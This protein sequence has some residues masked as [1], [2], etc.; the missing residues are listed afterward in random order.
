MH[1]P[2]FWSL[3]LILAVVILLFGGKKLPELG[4]SIGEAIKNFKKSIKDNEREANKTATEV[5]AVVERPKELTHPPTEP[6][7]HTQPEPGDKSSTT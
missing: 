5:K 6:A 3:L 2:G 1:A 4:G 7:A